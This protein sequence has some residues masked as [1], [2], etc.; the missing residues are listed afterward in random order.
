[1]DWVYASEILSMLVVIIIVGMVSFLRK[2]FTAQL[3]IIIAS[4]YLISV[5]SIYLLDSLLG[6]Q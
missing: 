2:T 5:L 1:M 4:L 3:G 6:W